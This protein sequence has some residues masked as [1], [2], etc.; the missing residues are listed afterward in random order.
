[1]F[2]AKAN[3]DGCHRAFAGVR[4]SFGGSFVVRKLSVD[5]R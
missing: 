2:G 3:I 4:F 1:M 5:S